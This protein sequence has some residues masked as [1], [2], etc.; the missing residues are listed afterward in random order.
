[1]EIVS[2][3]LEYKLQGQEWKKIEGSGTFNVPANETFEMKV[4]SLVD[5]CCSYL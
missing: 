2:G 5:Y 1:M 4:H 3:T